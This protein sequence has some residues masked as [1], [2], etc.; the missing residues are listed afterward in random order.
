MRFSFSEIREDFTSVE[1][2]VDQIK[3]HKMADIRTLHTS[4]PLVY[5]VRVETYLTHVG[6]IASC[7]HTRTNRVTGNFR[8]HRATDTMVSRTG[9]R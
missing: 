7:S 2:S 8:L 6:S 5:S 3:I 4:L 1:W 9:K